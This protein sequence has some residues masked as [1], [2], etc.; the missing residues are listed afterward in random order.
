MERID[1][2]AL[3]HLDEDHSGGVKRLGRLIPIGC[4]ATAREEIESERGQKYL[5]D[6][7]SLGIRVT[8]WSG[9]CVPYPALAPKGGNTHGKAN[10]HMGAVFVP[11][12]GGGFYLSAGDADA[13]AEPRIGA[14]AAQQLQAHTTVGPRILKIS[15]HG[16][17]TSSNPRFIE[18]VRPTETWISVGVGNRYGHPSPEVI[19]E[20]ERMKL[21]I[22]RTD[23]NGVLSSD[24]GI[25][26][27][28]SVNWE[29]ACSTHCAQ[30]LIE[31]GDRRQNV[32]D[33]PQQNGNIRM[34]G[35][36]RGTTST[37]R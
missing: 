13:S 36:L 17:K 25:H 26:A 33:H 16:S 18:Q 9:D 30:P 24:Q 1:W 20:L 34:L 4:V 28:N 8:D 19:S 35:G 23:M 2:V 10:D 15:H 31:L 7:E 11:L 32:T 3:T 14:W 21:P 22:R 12:E 29:F 27:E 5:R 37:L 6:L